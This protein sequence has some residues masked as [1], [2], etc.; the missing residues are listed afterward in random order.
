[1]SKTGMPDHLKKGK[2]GEELAENLLVSKGYEIIE[3][4]YRFGRGEIDLIALQD[5]S[6]LVFVEVKSR[7]RFNYG[8]PEEF[9]DNR[10]AELVIKTAENYIFDINWQKDI[11]FD[12]ISISIKDPNS[13]KHFEDA[14]H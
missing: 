2:A 8:E 14:F 1:M 12:I 4:N 3:R 9:V 10:K 5:D 7:S 13:I 6:I 11:R